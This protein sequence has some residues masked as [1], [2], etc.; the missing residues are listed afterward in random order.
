[1]VC[2]LLSI[3]KEPLP[4][5]MTKMNILAS[6]GILICSTVSIRSFGG[7]ISDLDFSRLILLVSIVHSYAFL[8]SFATFLTNSL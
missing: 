2:L 3:Q 6:G 4:L 7:I 1:M 5:L 8:L